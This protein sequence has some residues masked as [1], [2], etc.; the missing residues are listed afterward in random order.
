MTGMLKEQPRQETSG[1]QGPPSLLSVTEG[2]LTTYQSRNGEILL[3]VSDARSGASRARLRPSF[4]ARCDAYI[5]R[6]C[7][8]HD[9]DQLRKARK[10]SLRHQR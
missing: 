10:A 3:T 9:H 4:W 8:E 6:L 2:H 1:G 5:T 7:F